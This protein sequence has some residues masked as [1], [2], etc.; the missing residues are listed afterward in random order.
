MK[1]ASAEH[2]CQCKT[3]KRNCIRR[4]SAVVSPWTHSLNWYKPYRCRQVPWVMG[5]PERG[6]LLVKLIKLCPFSTVHYSCACSVVQGVR[7]VF[8]GGEDRFGVEL[9]RS[10]RKVLVLD[11]LVTH[12][13]T[14]VRYQHVNTDSAHNIQVRV[15]SGM[16]MEYVAFDTCDRFRR[17]LECKRMPARDTG[18]WSD[19]LWVT[20]SPS[21]E[22]RPMDN[23]ILCTP[24]MMYTTHC[25]HQTICASH[26]VCI[27][28]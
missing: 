13:R 12:A 22:Q 8:V 16:W 25:G 27:T 28:Y 20:R 24:H 6:M 2:V 7:T 4:D 11:R 10:Q 19:D 26:I 9:H 21:T 3:I 17:W 15:D 23:H 18:L 5:F 1:R 14:H